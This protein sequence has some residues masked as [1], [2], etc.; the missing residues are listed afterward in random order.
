MHFHHCINLLDLQ[1]FS[2]AFPESWLWWTAG[3]NYSCWMHFVL[4]TGQYAVTTATTAL[5]VQRPGFQK[6]DTYLDNHPTLTPNHPASS[7][8]VVKMLQLNIAPAGHSQDIDAAEG[9]SWQLRDILEVQ[10]HITPILNPW[11]L[12]YV[13]NTIHNIVVMAPALLCISS[14]EVYL[15]IQQWFLRK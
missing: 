2:L 9:M 4:V 13:V 11:H 1:V 8:D 15:H 7:P 5:S 12:M 6:S 14:V 3:P 10:V